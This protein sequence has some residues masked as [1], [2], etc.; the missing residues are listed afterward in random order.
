MMI[1]CREVITTRADARSNG[2]TR[3]FTGKRCPRGHLAE[4]YT[5][6]GK[7]CACGMDEVA[8]WRNANREKNCASS[9][10]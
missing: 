10:A 2:E 7:C 6:D 4:R 1:E 3:Y 8:A 9:D 5:S